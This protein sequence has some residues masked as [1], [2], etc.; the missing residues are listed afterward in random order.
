[1][2]CG[3]AA[4]WVLGLSV[5]SFGMTP[6]VAQDTA[7]VNARL[8]A[9]FGEHEA[10]REFL[11]RLQELIARDERREVAALV[12][13]PLTTGRAGRRHLIRTPE[14][15]VSQYGTLLPAATRA[16][17]REQTYDKLFAN[18]RGVM[19]GAGEIWFSAVCSD[20]ACANRSMRIVAINPPPAGAKP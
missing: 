8:D 4:G 15:F 20:S 3:L 11:V 14:Q 16:V 7:T 12:S 6:A 13:Y 9:L 19:I 5:V 10:Y 2:R 1:M 18:D 17:V